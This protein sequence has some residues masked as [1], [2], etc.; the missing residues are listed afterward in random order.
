VTNDQDATIR[1]IVYRQIAWCYSLANSLRKLDATEKAR[2]FISEEDLQYIQ[3]RQNKPLAILQMQSQ[4]IKKLRALNAI[5]SFSHVQ[6][7][8]TL[9][10]LC[11]SQGKAERIKSTIFPVTYRKFL[12]YVIYLF[13]I[14]LSVS[15]NNLK[16]YW[17]LPLLLLIS[18]AFFLL[19]KS[20]THLQDPF[21]DR[22]TDTAMNSIS[23][24]IE[25]NLKQ[26]LNEKDIPAVQPPKDFYLK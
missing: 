24:T 15:L 25:I 19:E 17:E 5:D 2:E 12:H 16:F 13:V 22:P 7:D 21:E 3:S 11:D 8:N 10:R 6:L 26:L 1:K 9:V 4:D 20:A 23:Q 14:S 18:S